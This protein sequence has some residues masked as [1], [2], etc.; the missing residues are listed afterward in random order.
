MRL[1]MSGFVLVLVAGIACRADFVAPSSQALA[2]RWT[3]APEPLAPSGEYLRTLEF[4]LDGHYV[5][6]GTS[7]G[8]YPQLPA[9]SVGSV[10]REYGV[11][12]FQR[13]TLRF[14][15]DSVRSWDYLSGTYFYAGPKGIY[16][17]GPPTDPGVELTQTRLT[18]RYSVNPGAGY[19]PVTDVYFRDP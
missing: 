7:R 19:V 4:T 1:V 17:E 15:Q 18:L 8:V 14:T 12:V 5:L 16:I 6:T 9:N 10:T 3:R 2:G 13:D 11:Y